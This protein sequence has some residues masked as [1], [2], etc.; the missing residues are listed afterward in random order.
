MIATTPSGSNSS[1]PDFAFMARLWCGTFSGRSQRGAWRARKSAV[2]SA[3]STSAKIASTRGF[4]ASRVTTS[5]ISSRRAKMASRRR[6]S[7]AQRSRRGRAAQSFCALR[8][9]AK[10]AAR[11]V[12]C[13]TANCALI[14][15]VAGLIESIVANAR[16]G[17]D[18]SC[19]GT[20]IYLVI[21]TETRAEGGGLVR[22][23]KRSIS[24]DQVSK[25]LRDR[26]IGCLA[27][28][29]SSSLFAG[30][31]DLRSR[32]R[33]QDSND[34]RSVG[35][36]VNEVIQACQLVVLDWLSVGAGVSC[37]MVKEIGLA[38]D[39]KQFALKN[40]IVIRTT[41]S[42][43]FLGNQICD[44]KRPGQLEASARFGCCYRGYICYGLFQIRNPAI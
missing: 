17:G 10:I 9:R 8:A 22:A 11:S 18:A 14:S 43:A 7:M 39:T 5:A 26:I 20:A 19:E 15:C 34:R 27:L 4:P 35:S 23:A 32:C 13:V 25:I 29:C 38:I 21:V 6:R 30:E 44:I 16:E 33:W 12:G 3:R 41:R 37:K 1:Q 28:G 2:S 36:D 24:G 42:G 31:P 40:L